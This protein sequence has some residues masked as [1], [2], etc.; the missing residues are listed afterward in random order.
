MP[1]LY[2]ISCYYDID[3]SEY[4]LFHPK[5][6]TNEW[7]K[8]VWEGKILVNDKGWFEGVINYSYNIIYP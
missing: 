1:K 2:D 4:Y 6:S 7:K 5:S 8:C 3:S